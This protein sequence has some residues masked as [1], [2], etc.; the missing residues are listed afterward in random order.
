MLA[1]LMSQ[2]TESSVFCIILNHAIL[3]T[4]LID[5]SPKHSKAVFKNVIEK[6]HHQIKGEK[7]GGGGGAGW[8]FP[9]ISLL[10]REANCLCRK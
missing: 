8:C 3:C 4:L 7:G 9:F 5:I 10:I 2:S 1:S 6:F